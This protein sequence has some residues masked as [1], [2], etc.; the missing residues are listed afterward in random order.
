MQGYDAQE[1]LGYI[2][3]NVNRKAFH[4]LGASAE[5]YLRQAQDLDLAFMHAT[6]VLDGEGFAGASYYDEDEAFE[7]ILDEMVRQRGLGEE[8]ELLVASLINEYM[9]AQA[10]YLEQKGL[11]PEG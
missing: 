3:R 9:Q 1:A 4:G 10:A 11:A 2:R 5:G 8:E 6:G 7:Y